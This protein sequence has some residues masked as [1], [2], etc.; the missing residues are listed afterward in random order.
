MNTKQLTYFQVNNSKLTKEIIVIAENIRTPENVGM[1]L[2]ISEAFGV[3]KVIFVGQSPNLSNKKVLRTARS[4]AKELAIKYVDEI[5]PIIESLKTKKFQLIGLELTNI[6]TELT[7][8]NFSKNNKIALFIGAE[9]YGIEQKTLQE[10]DDVVHI[11]LFGKNSSI[12]VVNALAIGL[13]EIVR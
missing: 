6:S 3:K 7:A 8:F 10:L 12:N 2:R 9:R 13:Y 5:Q 11:N 4:T 1:I